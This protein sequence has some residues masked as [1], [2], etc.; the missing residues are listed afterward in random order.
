MRLI[1]EWQGRAKL[2]MLHA[3]PSNAMS[4]RHLYNSCGAPQSLLLWC[5]SVG[6]GACPVLSQALRAA[7]R[8]NYKSLTLILKLGRGANQL[9]R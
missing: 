2:S 1:G 6:V 4:L 8:L 5:Q 7:L 9:R 3:P